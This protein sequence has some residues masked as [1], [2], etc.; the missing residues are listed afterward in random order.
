VG[1]SATGAVDPNG[2]YDLSR[3]D[4]DYWNQY[5]SRYKNKPYTSEQFNE[6]V[7]NGM[8]FGRS[9]IE[10][11][12]IELAVRARELDAAVTWVQQQLHEM[13][14]QLETMKYLQDRY[15]STRHD[16]TAYEAQVTQYERLLAVLNRELEA[17]RDAFGLNAEKERLSTLLS[18]MRRQWG[19]MDRL[20]NTSGLERDFEG[21]RARMTEAE[22]A[23]AEVDRQL[24]TCGNLGKAGICAPCPLS[25]PGNGVFG[26]TGLGI[27]NAMDSQNIQVDVGPESLGGPEVIVEPLTGLGG[28]AR[29]GLKYGMRVLAREGLETAARNLGDD[30][31]RVGSDYLDDAFRSGM[32]HAGDFGARNSRPLTTAEIAR[33]KEYARSLGATDDM[34]HFSDTV[35]TSY[36]DMFGQEV[37]QIGPDLLPGTGTVSGM[38]ANARISARGV[39]AHELVGHR[40][41]KQGG[42]D[43]KIADFSSG[44]RSSIANALEEAQASIRAA[45]FAPGLTDAERYVLLRDAVARLRSKGISVKDARELIH[46]SDP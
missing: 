30:G 19:A 41:A 13:R 23:L 9:A 32:R 25:T 16:A 43:F 4:K 1:N 26:G 40:A 46:V 3:C 5:W 20:R 38:S 35:N 33:A 24:G 27:A 18:D 11:K 42:F 2:L 10:V 21:Y 37:L 29:L 22:R 34:F 15:G 14:P 36:G 7:Q 31:L 8:F 6:D 28:L 45:R 17:I 39:I 12:A 44:A